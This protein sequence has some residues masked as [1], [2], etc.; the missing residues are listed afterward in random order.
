MAHRTARGRT[1]G[2][3]ALGMGLLLS[4]S[5]GAEE[6][7]QI[8][9]TIHGSVV[10][11]FEGVSIV[12]ELDGE[13]TLSGDLPVDGVATAFQASGR[14]RGIAKRAEALKESLGW[15]VFAATGTLDSGAQLEIHGAAI[16][17]G[18]GITLADGLTAYGSGS[19]V[20]VILL[21]NTRIETT[22]EIRG[23]GSGRL[24]PAEEPAAIAFSGSGET[25]LEPHSEVPGVD[26]SN[27]DDE[28]SLDRLLWDLELWPEE[29]SYEFL[30]LFDVVPLE[31][32]R[33][34]RTNN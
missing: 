2:T 12:G 17:R 19:F 29:L 14:A 20:L 31:Q 22:G 7:Q 26:T 15:G 28:T 11:R 18:E 4:F 33:G 21:E 27:P 1:I 25:V 9:S 13:I 16:M 8:H 5:T 32:R 30:R 10:I 23:S 24:V 3:L 34:R 6:A